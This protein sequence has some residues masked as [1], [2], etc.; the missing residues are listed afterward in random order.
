MRSRNMKKL[1]IQIVKLGK[2]R[3]D[4][5]LKKL[6]RFNSNI[7]NVDIVEKSIPD[8][9]FDWRYSLP[10]LKKELLK[11]FNKNNYDLC[12]GFIDAGLDNNFFSDCIDGNNMFVVSFYE[13]E[14]I[15]KADNN[16]VFNYVLLNIYACI[17]QYKLG[18]E[19]ISHDET[20]GC[21]FDMCGNKEDIV[22]SCA[23]PIICETCYEKISRNIS[24]EF[25]LQL[26]KEIKK[27]RKHIY[28]RITDFIKKHP[29]LS[30][31][32]FSISTIALNIISSLIYDLL[33]GIL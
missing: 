30:L 11:V 27:I 23:K 16:D 7:F 32:A 10:T 24:T 1:D 21:L 28:Y 14:E 31:M 33:K 2:Q 13:V 22:F 15:V 17:A 25:A 18:C 9:D 29:Y 26:K 12:I 8:S 5:C 20:K 3:H 6:K 19:D 4:N